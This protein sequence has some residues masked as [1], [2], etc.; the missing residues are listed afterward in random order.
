MAAR[1]GVD[2]GDLS[3]TLVNPDYVGGPN[4][5]SDTQAPLISDFNL[6]LSDPS[7]PDSWA[8]TFRLTDATGVGDISASG[9]GYGS[10]SFSGYGS[11][12]WIGNLGF[13]SPDGEEK[14]YTS[15]DSDDRIS[16]DA[17]SGLYSVAIPL[18]E[19]HVPGEWSLTSIS[20]EDAVG[21]NVDV[22][23][24]INSGSWD[25]PITALQREQMAA[26]LGLAPESL[27]L[28]YSNSSY[29]PASIVDETP[30]QLNRLTW[31]EGK[32]ASEA[33]VIVI[34]ANVHPFDLSLIHI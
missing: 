14:V 21:N 12:S 10:G 20:V 17:Q 27:S 15:I 11:G 16:G 7:R 33:D 32:P 2:P 25:D 13:T 30:P 8:A 3:F 28:N 9:G 23:R 31:L 5:V 26:R 18:D 22:S 4:G 1:L 29:Q 24:Q 34:G 19:T 6:R